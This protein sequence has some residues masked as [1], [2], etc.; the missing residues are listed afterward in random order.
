LFSTFSFF[1]FLQFLVVGSVRLIKLT[2]VG[3]QAHVKITSRIVSYRGRRYVNE[4]DFICLV[5]LC[6]DDD[7][8]FD[9]KLT[10]LLRRLIKIN[11]G[12]DL[13]PKQ[14]CTIII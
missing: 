4:H 14:V 2:H 6:R 11:R 8:K 12:D 3:F 5:L 1:V 7:A 9:E 10:N 13:P